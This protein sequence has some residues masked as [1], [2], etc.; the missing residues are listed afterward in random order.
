MSDVDLIKTTI[1]RLRADLIATNSALIAL[2]TSLPAETQ[3]QAL[4]ALAELSVVR[5]QHA[6]QSPDPEAQEAME[7]VHQ[8][9]ERLYQALQGAH[10]MRMRKTDGA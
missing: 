5:E 8:A 6:E 7:L 4:K 9:T 2:L 10:K 3:R 1:E